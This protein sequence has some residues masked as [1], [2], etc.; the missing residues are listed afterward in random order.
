MPGGGVGVGVVGGFVAFAPSRH[1]AS[2]KGTN[3][4]ANGG[5]GAGVVMGEGVGAAAPPHATAA[6]TNKHARAAGVPDCQRHAAPTLR[7]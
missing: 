2:V 4:P 7:L 1:S 3:A 5:V 6:A